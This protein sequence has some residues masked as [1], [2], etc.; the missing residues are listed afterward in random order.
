MLGSV[1]SMR[2]F[3]LA[4]VGDPGGESS[5]RDNR[6]LLLPG[7]PIITFCTPAAADADECEVCMA[8]VFA[9]DV[10]ASN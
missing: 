9:R 2:S 1:K 10:G 5:G 7:V 8:N 6:R 4:L 3:S